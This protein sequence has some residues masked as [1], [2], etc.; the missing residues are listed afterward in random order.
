M[1]ALVHIAEDAWVQRGA[2][3]PIHQVFATN[4]DVFTHCGKRLKR[5]GLVIR[6][7]PAEG[8]GCPRCRKSR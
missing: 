1:T 8:H 7:E 2:R 5:E 4:Y 6:D 3:G